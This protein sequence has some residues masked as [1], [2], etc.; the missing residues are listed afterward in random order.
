MPPKKERVTRADFNNLSERAL[1]RGNLFDIAYKANPDFK[2]ACVISKKRVKLAVERNKIRRKAY[3]ALRESGFRKPYIII[4]YP[5][6][7]MLRSPKK[8]LVLELSKA[9]ATLK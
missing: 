8:D 9:L 4:L 1:L 7:E 2:V 6:I 3:Y 5:R